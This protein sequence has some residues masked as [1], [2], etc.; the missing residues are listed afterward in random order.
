MSDTM[1][2]NRRRA[3]Q[4]MASEKKAADQRNIKLLS[5]YLGK[6][7]YFFP[8][9]EISR[10]VPAGTVEPDPIAPEFC[11]GAMTLDQQRIAVIDLRRRLSVECEELDLQSSCV[12][13]A[14]HDDMH[15][16][17]LID[18]IG[19]LLDIDPGKLQDGKWIENIAH[20]DKRTLGFVES[21]DDSHEVISFQGLLGEQE[22]KAIRNWSGTENHLLQVALRSQNKGRQEEDV[23]DPAIAKL[24]G[25]Y[26]VVSVGDHLMGL[27]SN[28]VAEVLPNEQLID[29]PLATDDYAGTLI[30]R[31]QTFPVLDLRKHFGFTQTTN[32]DEERT[33]IVLVRHNDEQVGLL[34]QKVEQLT[35]IKAR[36]IQPPSDAHL[37]IH[38]ELIEGMANLEIGRVTLLNVDRVMEDDQPSLMDQAATLLKQSGLSVPGLIGLREHPEPTDDL[39]D[40]QAI[41]QAV[42][43]LAAEVNKLVGEVDEACQPQDDSPLADPPG[44]ATEAQVPAQ[45]VAAPDD[46][47][48][49]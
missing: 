24:V 39:D 29:L 43:E 48:A 28:T 16:G 1:R 12:V 21:G 5:M 20:S 6:A 10:I 40:E 30:L 2:Q 22:L 45:P 3:R 11:Y 38:R 14:K 17:Y 13:M 26:L 25:S 41:A 42:D 7:C 4:T 33:S 9:S 27:R 44:N 46:K 15:V 31:G 37:D 18:A 23:V 34:V 35:L 8:L 36:Q 49:Q 32:V 19:T 47:A